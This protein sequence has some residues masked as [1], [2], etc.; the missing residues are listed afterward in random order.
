MMM[1]KTNRRTR[2]IL[3]I[4]KSHTDPLSGSTIAHYLQDDGLDISERT[5]RHYLKQMD[6]DGLTHM[7]GK[8][9]RILTGEGAAEADRVKTID[10][11]G[12]LSAKIDQLSYAMSFDREAAE[13]TVI[14]NTIIVKPDELS[15][16]LKQVC[17]VFKC[18]YAMGNLAA[19]LEPGERVGQ[20]EIPP[21][22]IGFTTVCSM[23]VN[24]ILLKH[25][26]PSHS[27]FGGILELVDS[28]ARR[29]TDLITYDG[30]TIDPLEVFIRSGMTNYI[31]AITTG[32]GRIGA[33]F[34]EIPAQSRDVVIQLNR[35]LVEL[36]LGGI[37]E[38][39][40][41][42]HSIY[43]IPVSEGRAGMVLIGGLNPASILEENG[44]RVR[45]YALSGLLGY[46]RLRHYSSLQRRLKP[47]L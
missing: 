14:V 21:G 31:G 10:R 27:R 18:G 28:K 22:H 39:G 16:H 8:K 35:D 9:G 25:R 24:G 44:V 26:I 34:R 5:V 2:A 7:M 42:G 20:V 41:A 15:R 12:F 47:Y 37:Y 36:G 13:G 4:L 45:A 29:F 40:R 38:I 30:T 11:V 23:T 1:D 17:M 33:S 6:D 46:N 32:S 43:G 19:I 3:D